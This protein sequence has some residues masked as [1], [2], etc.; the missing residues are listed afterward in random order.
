MRCCSVEGT[1]NGNAKSIDFPMKKT[2]RES[3][4]SA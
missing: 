3:G 1:I 2:D 4:D